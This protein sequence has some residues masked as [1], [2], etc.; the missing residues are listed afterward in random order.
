MSE[1]FKNLITDPNLI[2][3]PK[4]K[5]QIE[6]PNQCAF[7]VL[8]NSDKPLFLTKE[9]RRAFVINMKTTKEEAKELLI[10]QGYKKD[11]IAV[12]NNPSAF[13]WHLLNEVEYDREM[14]FE[15]APMNKD[16]EAMIL[17]NRTE[18]EKKLDMAREERSFP[19]GNYTL[20]NHK[21][22]PIGERYIYKGLFNIKHLLRNL[23]AHPEFKRGGKMY[24]GIDEVT[25][26]VKKICTP[27]PNGENTKQMELKNGTRPRVYLIEPNWTLKDGSIP[28]SRATPQQLGELW[29]LEPGHED[30]HIDKVIANLPNYQDIS[31]EPKQYETKCWACKQDIELTTETKCEEC[32]YAIKCQCGKCA[33]DKPGSKIKKKNH[34]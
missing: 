29:E 6:I 27:F 33:C 31:F 26:Y 18:F 9:D 14:F 34:Y 2:I 32:D 13:K 30:M 4:N 28:L 1:E 7:W 21:E 23:E 5:P 10:N 22:E 15:D 8:S 19:F 24:Y 17:A 11:I 3:N 16:K 25:D 12:L 20:V